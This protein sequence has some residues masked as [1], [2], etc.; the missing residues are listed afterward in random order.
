MYIIALYYLHGYEEHKNILLDALDLVYPEAAQLLQTNVHERVEV[1]LKEYTKNTSEN[2]HKS[3]SDGLILHL[4]NI[5]GFSGNTY[6]APLPI[7]NL[8]FRI[9]TPFKPSKVFSMVNKEPVVY[10]WKN[11]V[12]ELKLSKLTDF[13]GIVIDK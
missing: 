8:S 3:V 6:F 11:G 7:A 10:S 4:V 5:T 1:I 13:E 2:R 9:Q 12:L